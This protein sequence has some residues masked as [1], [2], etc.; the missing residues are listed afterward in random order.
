MAE[1]V[2]ETQ[3]YLSSGFGDTEKCERQS[4]KTERGEEDVGTPSDGLKHVWRDET[5]DATV[6]QKSDAYSESNP[7]DS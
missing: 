4:E 5:D 7:G 6:K 3:T 2:N 1:N